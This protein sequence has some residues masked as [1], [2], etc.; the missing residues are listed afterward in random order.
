M[1]YLTL[2]DED[3]NRIEFERIR[4]LERAH[5]A[6]SLELREL[7]EAGAGLD[8][9]TVQQVIREVNSIEA[10]LD[11]YRKRVAPA[12]EPESGD[13]EVDNSQPVG[14]EAPK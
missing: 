6:A 10:T 7:R 3:K 13:D 2:T 5:Y 8:V 9:P 1:N 12:A 4:V 14:E 11:R